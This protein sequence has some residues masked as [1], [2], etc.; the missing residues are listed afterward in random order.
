MIMSIQRQNKIHT[1]VVRTLM[2]MVLIV[3][4]CTF[5]FFMIQSS[6]GLKVSNSREAKKDLIVMSC[7]PGANEPWKT[8][9][10]KSVADTIVRKKLELR[11]YVLTIPYENTFLYKKGVYNQNDHDFC[12]VTKNNIRILHPKVLEG[13]LDFVSKVSREKFRMRNP[14]YITAQNDTT[15]RPKPKKFIDTTFIAIKCGAIIPRSVADEVFGKDMPAVGRTLR[16]CDR[17]NYH[18]EHVVCVY[19]DFPEYTG[20]ANNIYLCTN[21]DILQVVEYD[22]FKYVFDLEDNSH[23]TIER[24]KNAIDKYLDSLP[25]KSEYVE[26]GVSNPNNYDAKDDSIVKKND[27][28]ISFFMLSPQR[29]AQFIVYHLYDEDNR[30]DNFGWF[31][32]NNSVNFMTLAMIIV[33]MAVI[34]LVNITM[35]TVPLEMKNLNIRMVIGTSKRYVW[36]CQTG[37]YMFMSFVAFMLA[38]FI[39]GYVDS[40]RDL[41]QYMCTSMSIED[42]KVMVWITLLVALSIG[43]LC[44]LCAAWY[45]TSMPM[46][47]VLKAKVGMDRK[48]RKIRNW[49]LRVQFFMALYPL[50]RLILT[51]IETFV[52]GMLMQNYEFDNHKTTNVFFAA[53]SMFIIFVTLFCM[54]MQQNRYMYR[55]IAIRRALGTTNVELIIMNIKHYVKLLFQSAVVYYIV[56]EIV[57][58]FLIASVTDLVKYYGWSGYWSNYVA[59]HSFLHSSINVIV[60][61]VIITAIIVVSVL[62]HSINSNDKN[63]SNALKTE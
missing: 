58:F 50:C 10:I 12:F 15:D 33:L 13:S 26:V 35:T 61:C 18:S 62:L 41:V 30:H 56:M 25:A 48:M 40:G 53:S 43:A 8:D 51:L 24:I 19:E 6:F 36:M 59:I 46:D 32:K 34:C 38:M 9:V 21:D 57:Q 47:R 3:A 60:S 17:T 14:E 39:I 29:P 16:W 23:L 54:I 4:L 49:M 2:T 28:E 27:A 45:S 11:N 42:N 52:M 20:I 37:R 44:G 7:Y 55:S 22:M 31:K 5:Y 63:L 1:W